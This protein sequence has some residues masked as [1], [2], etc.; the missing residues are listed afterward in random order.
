MCSSDATLIQLSKTSG[1]AGSSLVSMTASANTAW[2]NPK[3]T[4]ALIDL[5]KT[6]GF[7]AIRIPCSWNQ[8]RA[9]AT[10]AQL[11]LF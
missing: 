10:T 11:K 6:D 9:N 8:N 1:N 5:V 4:K 7:N 3:G 2:G